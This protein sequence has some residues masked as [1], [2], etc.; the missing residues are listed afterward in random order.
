MSYRTYHNDFFLKHMVTENEKST[1]I[2][3]LKSL[4]QSA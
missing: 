4:L 1:N 3:N 2:L